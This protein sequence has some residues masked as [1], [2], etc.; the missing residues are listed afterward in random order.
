MDRISEEHRSWN[1]SRIR[2]RD[3]SPEKAVRSLL[4]RLKYRFRLHRKDLPGRPD[5]I[6]PRFRV[7]IFVH[8]CFW[9]RHRG[10]KYAYFP[11][12]RIEFWGKKFRENI[13][14][15][16]RAV[17]YLRK[18]GWRVLI[19]WECETWDERML[20]DRLLKFLRTIHPEPARGKIGKIPPATSEERPGL[21]D[22]KGPM[23]HQIG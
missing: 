9:H 8:G 5:I 3:T 4:H 15:D 19:I 22:C 20:A 11:K 18:A 23:S 12:S 10:C 16:R 6:L 1:M 17:R 7:A 2:D 14:R 13:Q 21:P